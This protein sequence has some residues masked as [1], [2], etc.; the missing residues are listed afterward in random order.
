MDLIDEK[1]VK[2]VYEDQNSGSYKDAI[3][4]ASAGGKRGFA[5]WRKILRSIDRAY[6]IGIYGIEVVPMPKVH[7]LHREFL[8]IVNLLKLDDMTSEGLAEFFDDLCPCGKKHRAETIRKLGKRSAK[9][10]GR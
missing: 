9:A 6:G 10:R 1:I 2:A 5:I 8:N 7:F 3:R 4:K